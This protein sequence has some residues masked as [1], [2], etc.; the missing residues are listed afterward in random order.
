MPRAEPHAV[1]PIRTRVGPVGEERMRGRPLLMSQ[2]TSG[3]IR[4][5]RQRDVRR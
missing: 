3:S 1:S 5:L 2:D 4:M